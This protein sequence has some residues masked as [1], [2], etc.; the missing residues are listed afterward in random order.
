MTTRR[1]LLAIACLFLAAG[2]SRVA[3]R[4]S[5]AVLGLAPERL[6]AGGADATALALLGNARG[7]YV[8]YLWYK[9]LALFA[10]DRE[11]LYRLPLYLAPMGSLQ[12]HFVEMWSAT[13]WALAFNAAAQF[14][15]RPEA[16]W[17]WIR[18]GILRMKEGIG[19]NTGHPKLWKLHRDLAWTYLR[20][21][22][23]YQDPAGA[24][25]GDRTRLE[26]GE[27]PFWEAIV[28]FERM[29]EL[30]RGE[31]PP[32]TMIPHVWEAW[33]RETDAP[34]EEREKLLAGIE[35]W[36]VRLGEGSWDSGE[37]IPDH[38]GRLEAHAQAAESV[39]AM[40]RALEAGDLDAAH[41]F[42]WNACV[43][44][45]R[46]FLDYRAFFVSRGGVYSPPPACVNWPYASMRL[47]RL[48]PPEVVWETL[49][50]T[51][52]RAYAG[53][54][55][56]SAEEAKI[57][58][59]AARLSEKHRRAADLER[60][61]FAV[62]ASWTGRDL[63]SRAEAVLAQKRLPE[64]AA[65]LDRILRHEADLELRAAAQALAAAARLNDPGWP[66]R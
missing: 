28:H 62:F 24:V 56:E 13:G 43:A 63:L 46:A 64:A 14:R 41:A 51:V 47:V 55:E 17:P 65:Y 5:A 59:E 19:R 50:E 58:R 2:G 31:A 18:A 30:G 6:L 12:P 20:K 10:E 45:A 4:E 48:H 44:Y 8:D 37:G 57:L 27:E 40:H 7:I 33:A 42:W 35:A 15:E 22:T 29:Q 9:S 34:G 66:G 49:A 1:S 38:R 3:L 21:C 61:P 39:G 32:A 54:K 25:W 36:D 26:L 11:Q 52:E 23:P 60:M 53:L 16:A